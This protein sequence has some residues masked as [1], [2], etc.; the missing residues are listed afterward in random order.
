MATFRSDP[1]TFIDL[2]LKSLKLKV[3]RELRF[4]HKRQFRFDWALVEMKIAIEYEGVY[5]PKYGKSRHTSVKGYSKDCE[6]YNL[7]VCHGWKVLR[8]TASNYKSIVDDL[9]YL[10]NSQE[11]D[12]K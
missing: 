12:I 10:F 11:V 5:N 4:H 9:D 1:K 8:Y 7:A 6:K 3:E 2:Y